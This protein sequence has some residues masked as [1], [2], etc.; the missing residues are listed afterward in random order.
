MAVFNSESN[1]FLTT[2][3]WHEGKIDALLL[4]PKETKPSICSEIP[5]ESP[6]SP[7]SSSQTH[8]VPVIDNIHNIPNPE[9]NSTMVISIG[10]GQAKYSVNSTTLR[11]R[12]EVSTSS[13]SNSHLMIWK[14]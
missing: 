13:V 12:N 14:T 10:E 8:A 9:P 6:D 5:F 2:Y 3:S 11:S 4:L 7:S 1:T